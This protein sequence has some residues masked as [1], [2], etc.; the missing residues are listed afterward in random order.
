MSKYRYYTVDELI[1][2]NI[3]EPPLDGNHG[4]KHPK[5][6]DFIK[7][8]IP[9]VMANDIE[10]GDINYNKC[11]YISEELSAKLTKGFS[12]CGDVL[13]T[14][15]GTIGRTA[16]VGGEFDKIVLTPQI[17]YYRIISGFNNMFLKYYFDSKEFQA[18]LSSRAGSGSTRAY[19]GITAQRQLPILCPPIE[20]Q[21]KISNILSAFDFKIKSNKQRIS[22]L[23]SI[24][25]EIYK[26]WF[27]DFS[28][29]GSTDKMEN[30]IPVGWTK[31][32]VFDNVSEVRE[33]NKENNDYPVLSVVKE[34]KFK[35]SDDVFTKQVYS[36]STTNY[37]IVRRNQI[38]YNPARA[39]IGSIAM[40]TNYDVGLVSPIYIVF[41]MKDTI[42][43]T[44]FYYYMKQPVFL[45]NIKHHAI[46]TT[47]QNFPFE[48]FKMFEMIVPPMELQKRFEEI[49]KPFEQKIVKLKEE[50]AVL[51]EIRDTLLPNLMSGEL[52]V[53]VGEQ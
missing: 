47:R 31:S 14:H 28:Y 25:Q 11:A 37:K 45:E 21:I 53:E 32:N 22:A 23:F 33:K 4:E 9:F 10:D 19:L 50:N 26:N 6:S 43:P 29:P 39:N 42:T 20:E 17:T 44:F 2:K 35:A 8:G 12:K 48:A 51:A 30:G 40:L 18:I 3:L 27:N 1:K 16:I 38:G 52:P 24:L 5:S 15:K 46:G 41:E 36:K 34:G 49:A 13:L 7:K